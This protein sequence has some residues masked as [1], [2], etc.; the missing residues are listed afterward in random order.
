LQK[1]ESY[2]G[3]AILTTNML[4]SL[5]EAFVRRLAFTVHF[6]FPE[7]LERRLIWECV[8]PSETPLDDDVDLDALAAFRL[9]GGNIKNA[10]LAAAFV[11]AEDDS[12]VAMRHVLH[13]V[14]REHEKL[15]SALSDEEL[16]V[17]NDGAAW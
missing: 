16:A 5:D 4:E 13:A 6:P 14:R 2:E 7:E 12:A 15:G 9:S 11:A 1:M 3:L 10:A 8:W 17:P